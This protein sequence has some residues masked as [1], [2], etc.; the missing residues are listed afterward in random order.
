MKRKSISIHYQPIRKCRSFG[1]WV[2]F[3]ANSADPAW[4]F[5]F[6]RVLG[7]EFYRG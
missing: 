3:N 7:W 4:Q 5:R 2:F 1:S 6:V